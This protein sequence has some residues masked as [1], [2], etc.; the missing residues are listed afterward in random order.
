[1]FL[2]YCNLI[3]VFKVSHCKVISYYN[4][5]TVMS[6][7]KKNNIYSFRLRP[8]LRMPRL[9]GKSRQR[10]VFDVIVSFFEQQLAG[11]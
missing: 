9:G 11:L 6:V 5:I 8:C 4:K 10:N 2:G 3:L 1:M 7:Q